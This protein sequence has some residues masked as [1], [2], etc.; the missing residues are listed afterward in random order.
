MRLKQA[1][2]KR[3]EQIAHIAVMDADIAEPLLLDERQQLG[4]A[5]DERLGADEIDFGMKRGLMRQMLAAAEADL[6]PGFAIRAEARGAAT[7]TRNRGNSVA[8]NS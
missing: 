2:R 6:E 3:F 5:I 1:G 7:S 4:D 8:I